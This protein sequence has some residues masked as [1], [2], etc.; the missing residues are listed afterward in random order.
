MTMQANT[1][2]PFARGQTM[3][4][5]LYGNEVTFTTDATAGYPGTQEHPNECELAREHWF[6][7]LDF[8]TKGTPMRSGGAVLCRALRNMASFNLLP[9]RMVY[10]GTTLST[11]AY[12]SNAGPK[13]RGRAYGYTDQVNTIGF[14]VDEFLPAAGVVQY[15]IFWVVVR[16]AATILTD[17]ASIISTVVGAAVVAATAAGSTGTGTTGVGGRVSGLAYGT[18]GSTAGTA[19]L[20][21]IGR[22]LTAVTTN[23]TNAKLLVQVGLYEAP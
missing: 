5:F 22:A 13:E 10:T 21:I 23:N 3:S 20:G 1:A 14:P 16:G 11:G 9:M 15:D 6:P 8:G 18:T 19:L 7:D 4:P 2:P 12:T 17:M